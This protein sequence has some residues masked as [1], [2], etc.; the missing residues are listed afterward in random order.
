[1]Y[2]I[3]AYI[4]LVIVVHMIPMGDFQLNTFE[5]G[6]LRADHLLHSLV[7]LPWMFLFYLKPGKRAGIDEEVRRSVGEL[8]NKKRSVGGRLEKSSVG[9]GTCLV[10]MGLGII[11]AVGTEALHY[12]VPYRNFN[13]MDAL[14][15]TLG[16][17]IGAVFLVMVSAAF[18]KQKA[19]KI[20]RLGW[21][22]FLIFG[23]DK[24]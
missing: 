18:A 21:S 10:W 12:W 15:N 16:V 5:F 7:F 17:L 13:P 14:F 2:F 24:R 1:M 22:L 23:K 19:G 6:P 3:Y 4:L 8:V 9:L 20:F 11:L